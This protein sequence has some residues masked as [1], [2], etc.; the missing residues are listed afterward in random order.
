MVCMYIIYIDTV[1]ARFNWTTHVHLISHAITKHLFWLN[2]N[3]RN[4]QFNDVNY[5]M[6]ELVANTWNKL[7]FIHFVMFKRFCGIFAKSPLCLKSAKS[8]LCLKYLFIAPP[9]KKGRKIFFFFIFHMQP[10][11]SFFICII[12][13]YHE[14]NLFLS[15]ATNVSSWLVITGK[16]R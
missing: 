3:C 9:K 12:F 5:L 16:N 7:N 13:F 11:I 4:V 10:N 8:P 6:R 14:R 1:F 2:Y 15:N